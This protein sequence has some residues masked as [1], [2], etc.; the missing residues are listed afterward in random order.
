MSN[1][2]KD[3]GELFCEAVDTIIAQRLN[4]I[5]YLFKFLIFSIV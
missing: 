4:E 3:Y 2:I 1:E 5:N